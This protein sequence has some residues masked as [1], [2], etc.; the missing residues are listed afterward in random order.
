VLGGAR[1]AG[2]GAVDAGGDERGECDG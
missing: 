2:G 1:A